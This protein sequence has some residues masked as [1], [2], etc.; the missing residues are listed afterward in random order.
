MRTFALIPMLALAACVQ[1]A[2]TPPDAPPPDECKAAGL[3]GLVGQ[4]KSILS[5]ML[6]PA[7]SRVIGPGD[8]VTADYS[9]ERLNVE[10]DTSG[11]I[12]KVSCY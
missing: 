5:T 8:A 7:G 6:L 4:P 11:R 9:P 3:Q 2:N 10:I 12:D 1:P